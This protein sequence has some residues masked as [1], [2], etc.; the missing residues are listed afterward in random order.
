MRITG[1][2]K[3]KYDAVSSDAALLGHHVDRSKLYIMER[4]QGIAEL[5]AVR[6]ARGRRFALPEQHARGSERIERDIALG[7]PQK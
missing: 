2:K 4:M 7:G 5:D 1:L 6:I 3:P